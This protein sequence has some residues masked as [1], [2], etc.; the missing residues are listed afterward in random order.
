MFVFAGADTAAALLLSGVPPTQ[1]AAPRTL[2]LLTVLIPQLHV[3]DALPAW[4]VVCVLVCGMCAP[5]RVCPPCLVCGM[6]TECPPCLVCGMW[7]VYW[8][9][10]CVLVCPPCLVCETCT[11]MPSL[12]GMW[13]MHW[14]GMCTCKPSLPGMCELYL[15]V[16]VRTVCMWGVWVWVC[17]RACV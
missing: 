2:E 16:G 4:Y 13:Y 17:V 7:H 3:V 11:G 5:C 9:V 14:Y 12:P 6:C 1:L 8:Y 15:C 10:V